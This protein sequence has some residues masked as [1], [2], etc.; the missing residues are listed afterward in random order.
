MST[1]SNDAP[2]IGDLLKNIGDAFESQQNRFNRAVY[3]AQPPKQ[4]DEILQN[5][6]NNGMPVKTISKMTGVSVS[7]IYSK[8]KAH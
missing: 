2:S 1:T 7:T 8:I 5:S 3:Q 4:Q 6:Y